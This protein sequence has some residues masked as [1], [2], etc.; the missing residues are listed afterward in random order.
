MF[1]ILRSFL[2]ERMFQVCVGGHLSR[3]RKL[4]NGVPQGSVLSVTLF[5]VAMQPIFKVVPA[6]VQILLYADDILLVVKG[7]KTEKLYRKLQSAVK[8]VQRWTK[9]VGFTIS[10]AKSNTFYCSP[11]ARREPQ[12]NIMIDQVAIP[13]TNLLRILGVTLDRTL[14]FKAH[15]K[16]AKEA[17]KSRLRIVKMIGAKL[18]RGNRKTLLQVGSAIVTS[19]LL[20]G[21]GLV[22]RGGPTV[23]QTLAPIYNQMVR[24][25]SGA[26]VTSPI[27]SI[28]AEAGTLPFE[29]LAMQ[30]A[31]RI[32]IRLLEKDSNY[33]SLPLIHRMSD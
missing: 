25:A 12:R 26:F 22:S 1:N 24:F 31:A 32:A 27:L 16:L 17:C 13:K 9:S 19:K 14:N 23:L 10:A 8:N 7:H 2:S 21:I 20:Y 5:L 30:S 15:C 11:N 33:N 4:E 28:M 3:A 6:G 29:L 18:R